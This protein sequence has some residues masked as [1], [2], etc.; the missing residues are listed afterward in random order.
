MI[1]LMVVVFLVTAKGIQQPR[2]VYPRLLE[3]RSPDGRMVLHLHDDLTLNLRKASVA[4]SEFRVLEQEDGRQVMHF[5]K[6]EELNRHLH[7]D[8]KQ[9]ASVH[10]MQKDTGVEVEGIVGPYHRIQPMPE[11]ERSE[12]GLV[13][14]M[15]HEIEKKEMHDIE[16]EPRGL[17]AWSIEER[18]GGTA[19]VPEEVTVELFIVT[20][21][22]HHKH[23]ANT[24]QLILYLCII[25]NSVNLRYTETSAPRLKFSLVGVEKDEHSSYK[26]DSDH[27]LESST[28]LDA[29][30][31]YANGKKH[32]YGEPDIVYLMTGGEVYSEGPNHTKNTN[33][34][35][36]GFVGTVCTT[37][38]VA[39][40]QDAA[41]MY[42]GMHTLAHEAGHVLGASHDQ[43]PP[44]PWIPNDPGSL[45]CL[46]KEGFM[47]SY[48]DGG[49]KHHRFSNCSLKQIRNV[50]LMAGLSCWTVKKTG[51]SYKGQYAGMVVK[52]N[53]Y[54]QKTVFPNEKNVTADVNSPKIKECKIRCQYPKPRQQCYSY[55]YCQKYTSIFYVYENALDYM[56]CG[57][58]MVCVRGECI[59]KQKLLT[60]A[61]ESDLSTPDTE[62]PTPEVTSAAGTT[63]QCLC[64]CSSATA[65]ARY[66]TT[67]TYPPRPKVIR[68]NPNGK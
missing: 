31:M 17:D 36:I 13:P 62:S 7:E 40:G 32:E 65:N 38:F 23:F 33:T 50:I 64:D 67:T 41:G 60:E 46:W 54:C 59:P 3:E 52:A 57:Q 29:F 61:P 48:V 19:N 25:V 4:A 27:Y 47:M 45:S 11:M 8:E 5:F 15:I 22:W 68:Y 42:S 56:P 20:D 26:T 6:G 55:G 37:H 35:G 24:S 34:L 16:M 44:K 28:T 30:Q 2:L 9:F 66:R 1:R 21:R 12:D 18:S 58:N 63:D 43:S 39:L 14:H 51:Y 10:L 49:T 53:D